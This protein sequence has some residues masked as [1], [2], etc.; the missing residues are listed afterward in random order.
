MSDPRV[1][2][3]RL[4]LTSTFG[5][6]FH[7]VGLRERSRLVTA[8]C[9]QYPAGSINRSLRITAA[10]SSGPERERAAD[11]VSLR[12]RLRRAR[13]LRRCNRRARR[14][15]VDALSA[16]LCAF[17]YGW[18]FREANAGYLSIYPLAEAA[19]LVAVWQADERGDHPHLLMRVFRDEASATRFTEAAAGFTEETRHLGPS[20]LMI[21][22]SSLVIT[23]SHLAPGPRAAR[24]RDSTLAWMTDYLEPLGPGSAPVVLSEPEAP[25][26]Y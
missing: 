24:V 5:A 11:A 26:I 19:D 10:F 2:E 21:R 20:P 1:Y 9:A 14:A 12:G 16:A 7:E 6:P 18:G 3:Q 22:G 25:P 15:P 17:G 23:S 13:Q 8:L 4:L